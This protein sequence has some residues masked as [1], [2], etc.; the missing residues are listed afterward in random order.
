MNVE[1]FDMYGKKITSKFPIQNSELI[2]NMSD[3]PAGIYFIK[4]NTDDEIVV[5]KVLKN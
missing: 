5:K 3:L 2:I 1:I 4:I